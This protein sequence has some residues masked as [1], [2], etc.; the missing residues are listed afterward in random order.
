MTELIKAEIT[1]AGSEIKA[2]MA[3]TIK[4]ISD[5]EEYTL[6]LRIVHHPDN[7]LIR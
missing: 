7:D 4:R 3:E 6:S 5:N 2:V 1:G